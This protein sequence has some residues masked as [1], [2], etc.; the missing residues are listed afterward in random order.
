[1]KEKFKARGHVCIDEELEG[2]C[3]PG[4]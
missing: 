4:A 1:M 2:D 3:M